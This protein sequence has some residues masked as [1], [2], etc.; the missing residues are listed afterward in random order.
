MTQVIV[1]FCLLMQGINLILQLYIWAIT[2]SESHT[3]TGKRRAPIKGVQTSLALT[4]IAG[5][6]IFLLLST[7]RVKYLPIIFAHKSVSKGIS[8]SKSQT[9]PLLRTS[10]RQ[11]LYTGLPG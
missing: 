7:A 1:T 11:I 9:E 4:I 10:E 5:S 6:F 2:S 3:G 8:A